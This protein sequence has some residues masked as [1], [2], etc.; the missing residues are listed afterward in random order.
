[1]LIYLKDAKYLDGYRVM[2]SFNDGSEGVAD[3]SDSLDG[4][5]FEPLNDMNYFSKFS[6]DSWPTLSWPNGADIAPEYLY[7][8]VTGHYP[9]YVKDE[10]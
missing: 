7:K 5:I 6:L 2:L 3:L 10:I 1:M 8:K 4:E 9:D